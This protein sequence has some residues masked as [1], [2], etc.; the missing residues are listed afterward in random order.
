MATSTIFARN[1]DIG[2]IIILTPGRANAIKLPQC[3][4]SWHQ[5]FRG[6]DGENQITIFQTSRQDM[7]VHVLIT[8]S[9]VDDGTEILLD[10]LLEVDNASWPILEVL[11]KVW[12]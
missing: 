2:E 5:A 8:H 9:K 3:L 11:N 1:S 10:T 7:R 4:G 6:F 12:E